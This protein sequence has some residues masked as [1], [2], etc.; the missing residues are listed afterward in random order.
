MI[1]VKFYL[2]ISKDEQARRFESRRDDPLR[3]WKLNDE[4]W[5]N[6]EKW[7]QYIEAAD[8][9]FERTDHPLAPWDVLSC[10]HKKWARVTI[11]ETLNQRV[12]EG[13]ARWEM[14]NPPTR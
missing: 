2:H 11:L 5:R 1:L 9:M 7:D 12:E 13:I 3:N 6:R 4:D 8:D 10:E 14:L